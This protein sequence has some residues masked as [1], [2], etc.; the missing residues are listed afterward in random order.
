[1][2][3]SWN[4]ILQSGSL[5]LIIDQAL[6]ISVE[7]HVVGFFTGF[8]RPVETVTNIVDISEIYHS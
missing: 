5:F 8:N 6:K 4:C 7:N 2:I 1:M 3:R